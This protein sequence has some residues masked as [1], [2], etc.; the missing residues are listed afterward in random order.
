MHMV[1]LQFFISKGIDQTCQGYSG[2][3]RE[4]LNYYD[5]DDAKLQ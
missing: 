3:R 2:L 1:R 4:V 5:Y